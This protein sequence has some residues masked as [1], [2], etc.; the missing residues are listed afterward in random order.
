MWM[1]C[2]PLLYF[3]DHLSATVCITTP[4][5]DLA[6]L[7]VGIRATVA[8]VTVTPLYLVS[9]VACFSHAVVVLV[10]LSTLT[11]MLLVIGLLLF[12][13]D[14]H[15]AYAGTLGDTKASRISGRWHHTVA[16][17]LATHECEQKYW[18]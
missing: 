11:L 14:A 2:L 17:G 4:V 18:K 16:N 15:L 8:P 12:L 1:V 10:I 13:A 6:P 5:I 7:R 3:L 9:V